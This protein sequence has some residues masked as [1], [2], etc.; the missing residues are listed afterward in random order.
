MYYK[1]NTWKLVGVR[2]PF[3]S[4][5]KLCFVFYYIYGDRMKKYIFP[6]ILSMVVGFYLGITLLKQYKNAQELTPVFNSGLNEIY[7]V[8][9]GEYD[10]KESMEK[11]MMKFPYYIHTTKDGKYYSYLG[12]STNLENANKIK[13]Y[14][15][16]LGYSTSVEKIGV[17]NTH[18]IEV[19]EEYDKLLTSSNNETISSICSQI[20]IKYEE[21][22]IN[23]NN[24]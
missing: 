17:S 5:K 10:T 2:F 7:F 18:F 6:I 21:L 4:T 20:L 8:R 9:K 24:N 14:Y 1:I 3:F 12:I 22:V 16:N 15:D 13:G 11:A 19:L 23:E